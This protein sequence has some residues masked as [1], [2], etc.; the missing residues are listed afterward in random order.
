MSRKDSAKE[1][2]LNQ[3][4]QMA[5]VAGLNGLTIG[6]LAEAV[7]MSKGGISAHFKSKTELQVAAVERAAELFQSA[8][9]GQVLAEPAGI[10]RLYKLCDS[11]FRYLQQGIFLGGCF[12]TNAVLELDDLADSEVRA[13]VLRYYQNYLNFI[14]QCIAETVELGQFRPDTPIAELAL[15]FHGIEIAALVWRAVRSHEAQFAT[16]R[17]AIGNLIENYRS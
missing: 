5:S 1:L 4:V 17:A 13:A 6:S 16:A 15:Q 10:D 9:V 7:A 12:F 3:A 8:V 14:E 11:W 2:I